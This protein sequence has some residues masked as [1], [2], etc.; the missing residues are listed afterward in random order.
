MTLHRILW[1]PIKYLTIWRYMHHYHVN[2][3]IPR[4][5]FFFVR[6][7]RRINNDSL[8]ANLAGIKIDFDCDD[9]NVVVAQYDTSLLSRILDKLAP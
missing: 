8:A 2:D 5:N 1:C 7:L 9:I 4:G 3:L 6:A